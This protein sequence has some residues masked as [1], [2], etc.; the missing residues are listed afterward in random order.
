ML[1][2]L[3]FELKVIRSHNI[4]ESEVGLVYSGYLKEHL[5]GFGISSG[6]YVVSERLRNEEDSSDEDQ[7]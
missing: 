6:S 1:L 4:E 7:S 2:Y 5:L 3:L